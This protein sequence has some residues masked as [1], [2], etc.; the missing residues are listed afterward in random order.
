MYRWCLALILLCSTAAVIQAQESRGI[1]RGT[2]LDD[3][4]S[5][6]SN[7]YVAAD[8]MASGKIAHVIE[9]YTDSTG[10]FVFENLAFGEYQVSAQKEAEGYLSTRPNI[11]QH[12]PPLEV[13]LTP[14]N[15][16]D[17]VTIRFSAKGALV[18]GTVRDAKTGAR[19]PAEITLK[20]ENGDGLLGTGTNGKEN[21]RL[22]IPANSGFTMT[23]SAPGYNTWTYHDDS[24]PEQ[25]GILRLESGAE[26]KLEIR[27]DPQR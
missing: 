14:D 4:G 26:K 12:N 13:R 7:A 24:N 21:F 25:A 6:V 10:Q 3:A 5:P 20:P 17:S 1:I 16:S 2:V 11:F 27:L 9:T 19:L 22:A 8:M 15:N 23:V 18:T